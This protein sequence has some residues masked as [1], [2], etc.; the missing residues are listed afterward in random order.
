[1]ITGI[2]QSNELVSPGIPRLGPAVDQQN[3]R[4]LASM[5]QAHVDAVTFDLSKVDVG[6]NVVLGLA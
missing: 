6:H 1:V 2:R 5:R 4:A 3:Q